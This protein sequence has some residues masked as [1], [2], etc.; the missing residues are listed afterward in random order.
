[1]NILQIQCKI[2][3]NTFLLRK[4]HRRY[5]KWLKTM[6][7]VGCWVFLVTIGIFSAN[8]QYLVIFGVLFTTLSLNNAIFCVIFC[9]F[10]LALRFF[11]PFQYEIFINKCKCKTKISIKG[12]RSIFQRKKPSKWWP[13]M[14]MAMDASHTFNAAS[15][16]LM[17]P[18]DF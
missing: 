6:L 4:T 16:V 3:F 18:M 2:D 17:A 15:V 1:M 11:W 9:S 14:V 13:N 5:K 8:W 12:Q 10:K 7:V